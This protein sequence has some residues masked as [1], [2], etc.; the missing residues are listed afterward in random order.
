MAI[1]KRRARLRHLI[2][3]TTLGLVA[4]SSNSTAFNKIPITP[5]E[6]DSWPIYCQ[7]VVHTGVQPPPGRFRPQLSEQ[8]VQKSW[9]YGIWHYCIGMIK[10]QRAERRIHTEEASRLI[11]DAI[12]DLMYSFER[13]TDPEDPLAAEMAVIIAR[14]YRV[15]GDREKALKYLDLAEQVR[16]D[17]PQI[18][19][20][21]SVLHF[22][23][24]EYDEAVAVLEGGNKATEG[25]SA[26]LNYFLGLAYLNAGNIDSAKAQARI[27][28]SLGYPLEG[29]QR[30]IEE[31]EKP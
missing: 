4:W 25:N 10:V 24:G 15:K 26:E 5:A 18:Y 22:D 9:Q 3:I 23:K 12:K 31:Y 14:A 19:A 13:V 30:Q 21:R 20:V 16:P 6:W 2:V 28:K 11:H 7:G 17:L 27:A 29:L 8:L 1:D